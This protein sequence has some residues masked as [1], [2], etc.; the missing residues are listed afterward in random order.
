MNLEE[1]KEKARAAGYTQICLDPEG[2]RP[3]SLAQWRGV[4][5]AETW[6]TYHDLPAVLTRQVTYYLEGNNVRARRA[7]D[8]EFRYVLT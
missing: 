1:L 2:A 6:G 5:T 8:K 3:V 7:G 4:A